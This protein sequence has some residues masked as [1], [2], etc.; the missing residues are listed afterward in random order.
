MHSIY[1][2]KYW[3]GVSLHEFMN[4]E[5]NM[6]VNRQTWMLASLGDIG[7]GALR[8][9]PDPLRSEIVLKSAKQNLMKFAFIGLTGFQVESRYLFEK[10]F[11]LHFP[12]PVDIRDQEEKYSGNVSEEDKIEI[13]KMNNLDVRLYEFAR[14]IFMERFE[15]AIDL[16]T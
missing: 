3:T 4:C 9:I 8:E 16:K 7:C 6:A 5:Y 10:T 14:S 11:G 2:G 1:R 12:S 15:N 13:L